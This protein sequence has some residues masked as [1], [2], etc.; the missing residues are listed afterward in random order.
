MNSPFPLVLA[1]F[2]LS[3]A[4]PSCI[5]SDKGPESIL[6]IAVEG[7]DSE[8]ISC[9]ADSEKELFGFLCEESVRFTHA[10]TPSTMSQASL[11]AILTGKYPI[12]LGIW[13]NGAKFLSGK[14]FTVAEAAHAKGYKTAFFSGGAPIWR[15][16]GLAQGFEVFDDN[17]EISRKK[18]H[19]S[20][21]EVTHRFK[22]WLNT[23]SNSE[24][25]FSV[26]FLADLQF[27]EQETKEDD[28]G[29]VRERGEKSQ[30]LEIA[31]S[32]HKLKK[33]LQAKGLWTGTHIILAGLNG[34][35]YSQRWNEIRGT[36]LFGE[37]TRVS[38]LVKPAQKRER[39]LGVKWKID[40]N[41][42]LVDIGR[43][44][45]DIIEWPL[46]LRQDDETFEAISFMPALKSPKVTWSEDRPILIE[47]G[48]PSWRGV[49]V[50]RFAIRK[51]HFIYIYDEMPKVFDSLI[52][53]REIQPMEFTNPV[54]D[55]IRRDVEER[56]AQKG[57][58]AWKPISNSLLEKLKLGRNFWK[59]DLASETI[60]TVENNLAILSKKRP[61]DQQIFGWLAFL[62]V[63]S[64]DWKLLEQLGKKSNTPVWQYV[65]LRMLNKPAKGV[66][67][68]S[69]AKL[70]LKKA[71]SAKRPNRSVC[72]DDLLLSLLDWVYWSPTKRKESAKISF[73]RKF[74]FYKLDKKIAI[75]NVKTGLFWDTTVDAPF[76]P[77]LTEL[78]LLLPEMKSIR[79]VVKRNL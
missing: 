58:E 76:S 67:L 31:E 47:S 20:V 30:K 2:L 41:V 32:I 56:L 43:T 55:P 18:F 63:E 79:R 25:F 61:W 17:V 40:N 51:Q 57:Y 68:S 24:S 19:R 53:R 37:N 69:C 29:T 77:S 60:K 54:L 3:I 78:F 1:I 13:H 49:G 66:R 52:D 12:D 48:W 16:S 4:L 70:F 38:L 74:N 9:T 5:W 72:D 46:E 45:F 39:D 15:K 27:P 7:L 23:F 6:V 26:L 64:K 22:R 44:L 71:A 65:A 11:S 35:S 21:S 59:E 14:E 10:Y 62:A 8:T 28:G 34:R 36:N 50:T 73:L 33:S 42:S 75:A